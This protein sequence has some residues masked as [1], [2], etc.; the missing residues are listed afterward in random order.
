[1]AEQRD[2]NDIGLMQMRK[3]LNDAEK[4][5]H[6]LEQKVRRDGGGGVRTEINTVLSTAKYRVLWVYRGIVF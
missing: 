4:D 6:E 5:K 2:S 3:Q 1:M